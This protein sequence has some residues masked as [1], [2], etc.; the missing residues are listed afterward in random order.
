MTVASS[1]AFPASRKLAGWWRQLIPY[2]PQALWVAHLLFHHVEALVRLEQPRPVDP[3]NH[4]LL[5]AMA[6]A[7]RLS[8]AGPL[9]VLEE[10]LG[11]GRQVLR[12]ALRAL[13]VEGLVES[14]QGQWT[15]TALGRQAL[16]LG[17]Y[18]RAHHERRTFY[19]VEAPGRAN[20]AARPPHFVDLHNST[21]I[22]WPV[23]SDTGFDIATLQTCL[24]RSP[25]WKARY[26]FPVEIQEILDPATGPGPANPTVSLPPAWQRIIVDRPEWILAVMVQMPPTGPRR[27]IGLAVRQEGWILQPGEPLFTLD[28]NWPEVFPELTQE[29]SIDA[30]QQAWRAWCEP[31]AI[32]VDE[33]D[34]CS[35]EWL[36]GRLR[37][38]APSRLLERLR[39]SRSDALRGETCLLAGEGKV[40]RAAQVE[41][42]E[43]EPQPAGT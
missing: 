22:A 36:Q 27:L 20:G 24:H 37:V 41:V 15:L 28:A 17:E 11:L 4:F 32:P 3:W 34:A 26:G 7:T 8:P 18:P 19:F 31:R 29:P 12:R 23:A 42:V 35:V 38:V 16:A 25:E 30:W 5:Q 2:Q 9:D 6:L 39:A 14:G 10:H 1:L 13:E 43:A 40:R 33:A 21:G